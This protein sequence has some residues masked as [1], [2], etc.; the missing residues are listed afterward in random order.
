MVFPPARTKPKVVEKAPAIP[1]QQ[2]VQKPGFASRIKPVNF[3]VKPLVKQKLIPRNIVK[4]VFCIAP[5]ARLN[6]ETA[7]C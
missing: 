1:T 2:L 3:T 7:R 6:K 5:R 4:C